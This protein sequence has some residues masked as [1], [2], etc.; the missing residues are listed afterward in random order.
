MVVAVIAVV[1]VADSTPA[2]VVDVGRAVVV[3]V[4]PMV[5]V[6]LP[7]SSLGGVAAVVLDVVWIEVVVV[8]GVV[9][10]VLGSVFSLR[11]GC[12]G[13]MSGSVDTVVSGWSTSIALSPSSV[14]VV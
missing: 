3:V 12:V 6:V 8:P 10:V 5:V 7:T 9:I 14:Q 11:R 2:V 1:V 13:V 4:G